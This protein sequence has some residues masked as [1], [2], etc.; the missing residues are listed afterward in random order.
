VA[1][2]VDLSGRAWGGF[3]GAYDT[4]VFGLFTAEPTPNDHDNGQARLLLLTWY[5]SHGVWEASREQPSDP[6]SLFAQRHELTRST[7]GRSSL[8]VP[9][10]P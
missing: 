6:R 3:E 4:E 8:L 9:R 7:I 5:A 10:E 2:F 1:D